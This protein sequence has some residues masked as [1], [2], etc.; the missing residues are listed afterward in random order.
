MTT[1]Q[2]EVLILNQTYRLACSPDTEKTLLEA[3]SYV[4]SEM[5]KIHSNSSIRGIDRIAVMTSISLASELLRLQKSI[6]QGESF[7]V[8]EIRSTIQEM[9]ESLNVALTQYESQ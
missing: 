9:N 7:P 6:R 8:E 4:D 2:I 5:T 3:V 1:K